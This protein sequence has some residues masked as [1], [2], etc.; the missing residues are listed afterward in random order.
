[1]RRTPPPEAA[2]VRYLHVWTWEEG[3]LPRLEARSLFGR[4]MPMELEIGCGT[5]EFLC[6]L[7]EDRPDRGFVGIDPSSKSLFLAVR[8]AAELGLDNIRF[9]RAPIAPVYPV[10]EP[11]SFEAVYVHFPD[12][13]VRSR[14]QHKVLNA[15]FFEAFLT[16]LAPGGFVSV[17]SD[18]D[19][20]FQ[21]A[22]ALAEAAPGWMRSHEDAFLVGY[23]PRVK[24]RYQLKWERFDVTPKRFIFQ[25]RAVEA[26]G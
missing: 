25:T 18:D 21:E 14:G 7:A 17:V 4:A 11:A 16:A 8:T 19:E 3:G 6:A 20:L 13:F 23:S 2:V 1:M 15:R 12:P 9:V 5:G 10:L 26:G 22:L 24:S